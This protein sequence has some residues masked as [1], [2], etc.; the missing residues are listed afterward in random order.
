MFCP[1]SDC[2]RNKYRLPKIK[3]FFMEYDVA[4]TY[5]SVHNGST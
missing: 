3:P 5:V 4:N 2:Q 1:K